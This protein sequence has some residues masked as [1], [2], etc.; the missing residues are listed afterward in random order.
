MNFIPDSGRYEIVSYICT[1]A[2]ARVHASTPL[3]RV[4]VEVAGWE[5]PSDSLEASDLEK[6]GL[7]PLRPV[8]L[9]LDG[10]TTY[11]L[12][13]E[14]DMKVGAPRLALIGQAQATHQELILMHRTLHEQD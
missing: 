1:C 8:V 2:G 14:D 10:L 7:L 9:T 6:R 13:A 12:T 3:Q 11:M 4:A 5:N